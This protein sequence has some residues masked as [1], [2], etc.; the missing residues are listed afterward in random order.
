MNTELYNAWL[1]QKENLKQRFAALTDGDL[2][3]EPGKKE[4]MLERLQMKL[5]ISVEEIHKIIDRI[6]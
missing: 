2:K 1:E 6:K 3:F 5:G 4:E